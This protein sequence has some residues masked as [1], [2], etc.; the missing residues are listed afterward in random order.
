[1]RSTGCVRRMDCFGRVVIPKNVRNLCGLQEDDPI[2][3]FIDNENNIILKKYNPEE[4][5]WSE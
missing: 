5:M 4:G 2:E 3:I 1:M